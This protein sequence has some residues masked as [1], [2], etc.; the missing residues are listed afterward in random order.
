MLTLVALFKL[1][2]QPHEVEPWFYSWYSGRV[3]TLDAEYMV[4]TPTIN[5]KESYL[6]TRDVGL[7][8]R[9]SQVLSHLVEF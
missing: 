6:N 7:F 1:L 2:V 8:L 5:S 4:A 3:E 9:S